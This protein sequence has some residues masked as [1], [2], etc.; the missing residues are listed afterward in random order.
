M[1][2]ILF[3]SEYPML[4]V[5]LMLLNYQKSLLLS[6]SSDV[7]CIFYSTNQFYIIMNFTIPNYDVHNHQS[8]RT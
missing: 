8:Q 4:A 1:A 3:M 6:W 7:E 5:G 2:I